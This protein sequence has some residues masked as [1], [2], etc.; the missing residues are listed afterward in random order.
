MRSEGGSLRL[1]SVIYNETLDEYWIY[2]T[3]GIGNAINLATCPAGKDGYSE[4]A[5]ANIKRYEGNPV[6]TPEGQ[7]RDDGD[8]VSQGAVFREN[9]LWYLFYS[10][11]NETKTLPGIRLATSR[12]G[13]RVD[14]SVRSR[15][16]HGG[17]GAALYRMAPG[18][19]DR[20]PLRHALRRL[21]R[22][23][24]LG[25]GRGDEFEPDDGLEKSPRESVRSDEM[26]EL[27]G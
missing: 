27:L 5:T 26:A 20:Q 18:L 14:E 23:H 15:P 25:R 4:V 22:R 24:P 19:Q 3:G 2:Y 17:P 1:D 16:A 6:L 8:C 21:Q 11:R 13:K 12:D 10:Y 7:G 9:G